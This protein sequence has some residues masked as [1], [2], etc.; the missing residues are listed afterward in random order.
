MQILQRCHKVLIDWVTARVSLDQLSEPARLAVQQIGDRI[1][2]YCPKTGQVR[3][4]SSAWDSI[5]SD[6]HQ[7]TVRTQSD[8]WMQGSPARVIG[9]GDTVFGSGPSSDLDLVGCVDRMRWFMQTQIGH[10]LPPATS[11]I[12]TR[13]DVTSN[14]KFESNHEVLEALGVLAQTS[15]GRYRVKQDHGTSCMWN[16]RSKLKKAIGYSK[17]DHIEWL[18]KQLH[19]T[20]KKYS[21]EEIEQIKKLLRLELRLGREFFSRI[22][23]R[24]LTS[25]DLA[26]QWH[27]F[28]D[29]MIG[30]SEVTNEHE[31]KKNI[32]AVADTEGQARAAHAC[33]T[34]IRTQGWEVAR[35][36]H[37]KTTWYRN[38]KILRAAGLGDAD[39]SQGEVVQLRRKIIEAQHCENWQQLAA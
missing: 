39:F 7:I 17:G 15:G 19:Y 25:E 6:T 26:N 3:Y 37:S 24:S 31:V 21:A 27:E 16:H 20:G 10:P 38:L 33:W 12:V 30:D 1:Q 35:Q 29:R 32:E 9:D 36:M 14:L 23:W 13:V 18:M 8:F 22:D 28:F 2:R 4:E 34:L 11:W 5:R